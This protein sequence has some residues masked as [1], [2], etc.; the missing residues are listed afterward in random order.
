MSRRTYASDERI[1]AEEPV[2]A[3]CGSFV[4]AGVLARTI[5]GVEVDLA[6]H[7][8]ALGLARGAGGDECVEAVVAE[9]AGS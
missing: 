5:A 9:R 3:R 4:T 7:E 6:L 2:E 1:G 8:T